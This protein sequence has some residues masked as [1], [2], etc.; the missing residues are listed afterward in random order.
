MVGAGQFAV[1]GFRCGQ[2]AAVAGQDTSKNS[3]RVDGGRLL[4][5]GGLVRR[6]GG[7]LAV[8]AANAA[9]FG[10]GAAARADVSRPEGSW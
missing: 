5:T 4:V 8:Q 1:Q 3:H 9:E 2:F 6:Q 10:G 7:V